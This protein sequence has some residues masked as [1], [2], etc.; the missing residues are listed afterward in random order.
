MHTNYLPLLLMLIVC[1]LTFGGMIVVSTWL[2]PRKKTNPVKDTP[3]ECGMRP[4]GLPLERFSVRFYL[5]AMLFILF[6]LEIVFLFPWAVVFRSLG[7]RGVV[8]V[9]IF[10]AILGAGYLYAWKKGALEWE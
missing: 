10:I 7:G 8:S 9:L 2:G 3:F 4:F 6:D 1:A 5:V